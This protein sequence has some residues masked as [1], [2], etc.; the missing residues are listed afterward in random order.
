MIFHLLLNSLLVFLI[1]SVSVELVLRVFN[2]TSA[3]LRYVCRLLPFFK[4]LFDFAVFGFYGESLG[5]NLNPFSCELYVQEM[6]KNILPMKESITGYSIIIPQYIAA[7]MPKLGLWAIIGVALGGSVLMMFKK[8][9]ELSRSRKYLNDLMLRSSLCD[10]E[11]LNQN[12]N[13]SMRKLN[14]KILISDEISIPFVSHRKIIFFPKYLIEQLDQDEFEAVT[15]HELE[16]LR[17]KDPH[18]RFFVHILCAL[19]WWIPTGWL[20]KKLEADQ[21]EAS[22]SEIQKYGFNGVVLG[23]AFVKTIKNAKFLKLKLA[24]FCPLASC[25]HAA[26]NRLQKMVQP[27][28]MKQN[29]IK[30]YAGFIVC[31][32]VIFSFW[33]C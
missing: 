17:W 6:L 23:S 9:K 2:I 12:L 21:E 26:F 14:A 18:L 3:R 28:E 8:W 11:I 25:N 15:A 20:I 31:L 22:D 30:V 27:I 13:S 5:M 24:H 7:I 29:K 33:M 4:V 32:I 19:L 10:R 1:I 16:H